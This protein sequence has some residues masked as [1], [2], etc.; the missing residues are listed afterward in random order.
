[1]KQKSRTNK[2]KPS[3]A[4][5]G[6]SCSRKEN[7][8]DDRTSSIDEWSAV[9]LGPWTPWIPGPGLGSIGERESELTQDSI[10]RTLAKS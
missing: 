6:Y 7:Y 9:H 8:H 3:E 2:I 1:M 10:L 5:N 4:A